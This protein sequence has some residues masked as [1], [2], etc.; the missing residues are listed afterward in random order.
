MAKAVKYAC[1]HGR[2]YVAAAPRETLHPRV[3]PALSLNTLRRLPVTQGSAAGEESGKRDGISKYLNKPTNDSHPELDELFALFSSENV[4]HSRLQVQYYYWHLYRSCPL[5][6][7][8]TWTD[9]VKY[10]TEREFLGRILLEF[11]RS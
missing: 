4:C 1:K 10:R 5:S 8:E 7:P 9:Y 11:M 2:D 6:T 3:V